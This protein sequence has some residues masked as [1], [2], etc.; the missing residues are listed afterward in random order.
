MTGKRGKNQTTEHLL[1]CTIHAK[2]PSL[3]SKLGKLSIRSHTEVRGKWPAS[4]WLRGG[5]LKEEA[6]LA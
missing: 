2:G 4:L 6:T 5:A 1:T 3:S